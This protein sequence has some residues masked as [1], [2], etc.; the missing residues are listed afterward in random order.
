M[1]SI[2]ITRQGGSSP[3]GQE[4][5]KETGCTVITKTRFLNYPGMNAGGTTSAPLVLL[6]EGALFYLF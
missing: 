2:P 1:I 4:C 3:Q 5:R 6:K